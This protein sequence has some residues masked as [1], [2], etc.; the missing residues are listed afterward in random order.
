MSDKI[1][2]ILFG[3]SSKLI[4]RRHKNGTGSVYVEGVE[5]AGVTKLQLTIEGGERIKYVIEGNVV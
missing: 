4:V 2:N 5:L 3:K 1:D